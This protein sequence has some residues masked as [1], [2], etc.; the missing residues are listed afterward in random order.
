[1]E[2]WWIEYFENVK[3]LEENTDID[4]INFYRD[5]NLLRVVYRDP[6]KE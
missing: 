3:V 1:M 2:R 4:V 6:Y 5:Y